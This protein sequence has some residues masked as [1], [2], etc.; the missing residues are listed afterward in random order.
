[1][2]ERDPRALYRD[3]K[4]S[5]YLQRNL[6]LY[7][8]SG[9]VGDILD[10]C[11][12]I[13]F[14]CHMKIMLW[15]KKLPR[16]YNVSDVRSWFF[17]ANQRSKDLGEPSRTVAFTDLFLFFFFLSPRY[18]KSFFMSLFWADSLYHMCYT[19]QISINIPP[20]S[21]RCPDGGIAIAK[22]A[23]ILSIFCVT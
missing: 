8:G 5:F 17:C 15:L 6:S 19:Q 4:R 20:P 14:F 21:H 12:P 9:N 7:K 2:T 10:F 3:L 16:G 1:M 13:S 22:Y 18:H 23:A 11:R